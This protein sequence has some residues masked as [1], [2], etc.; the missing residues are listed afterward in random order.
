MATLGSVGGAG[1]QCRADPALNIKVAVSQHPCQDLFE[2]GAPI[3]VPIMFTAGSADTICEDGCAQKYH[4]QI[5]S[6]P[7]KIM[8]NVRGASHFEPTSF[9]TN[10][11]VPAVAL[12]LSCWLR[13]EN[14][15]KVYGSSGKAICDQIAAGASLAE[16]T[17]TGTKGTEAMVV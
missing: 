15:D 10:S 1:T 13:D 17:V 11:E 2:N 9:G 14:C 5:K 7:S 3:K 16:C 4:D 12:F 8:F 6:S